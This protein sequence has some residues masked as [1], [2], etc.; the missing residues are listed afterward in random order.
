MRI[1][2]GVGHTD[3]ES[4][5]I[6]TTIIILMIVMIKFISV[7]SNQFKAPQVWKLG[8]L[9]PMGITYLTAT[10]LVGSFFWV[11]RSPSLWKGPFT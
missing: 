3:S 8:S 2:T 5:I 9:L 11:L 10:G 6:I 7:F 4:A 1:H